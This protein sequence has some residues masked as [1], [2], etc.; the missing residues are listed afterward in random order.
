MTVELY[1][2]D[3]LEVLPRL[4]A[5]SV[6]ACILDLPYGVTQAKHDVVIPFAP[7]WAEVKRV[8]K[9][10]GVFVTTA[11]QP[12]SSMLVCSNLAWFKYE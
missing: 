6:D 10:N 12:F 7:M 9:G 8:L 1:Q 4:A 3:C 5:G 11:S 2:G